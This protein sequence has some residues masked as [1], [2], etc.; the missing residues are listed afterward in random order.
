VIITERKVLEIK[1]NVE[2]PELGFT[3]YGKWGILN[4][5]QRLLINALC[6]SWLYNIN[7][8]DEKVIENEKLK[9][10]LSKV[11]KDEDLTID[12]KITIEEL[13]R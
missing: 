8:L 9:T 6:D 11:R 3:H 1:K 5:E 2:C 7:L 12:E 10:I 4:R 13:E